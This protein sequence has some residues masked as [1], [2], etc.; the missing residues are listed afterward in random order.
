MRSMNIVSLAFAGVITFLLILVVWAAPVVAGQT[1]V[2]SGGTLT[3]NVFVGPVD[4]SQCSAIRIVVRDTAAASCNYR[5]EI[6]DNNAL[7]ALYGETVN[8]GGY[9][10]RCSIRL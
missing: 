1:T 6:T 3:A 2:V 10:T 9:L 8:N 4:V 5:V 7:P